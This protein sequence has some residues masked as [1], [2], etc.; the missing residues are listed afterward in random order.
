MMNLGSMKHFLVLVATCVLFVV[1]NNIFGTKNET[2][3]KEAA[4]LK[5]E[6][7]LQ[8][9]QQNEKILNLE[10]KLSNHLEGGTS[11]DNLINRSWFNERV[12]VTMNM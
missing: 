1:V 11:L 12:I 5:Q 4:H 7:K 8:L 2:S 6:L 3:E 9:S 10:T